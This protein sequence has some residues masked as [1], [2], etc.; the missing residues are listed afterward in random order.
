[1]AE[2]SAIFDAANLLAVLN[3]P[4][5]VYK[6]E[7]RHKVAKAKLKAKFDVQAGNSAE[8]EASTENLPEN[9]ELNQSFLIET[10]SKALEEVED[11]ELKCGLHVLVS[12]AYT[13][14]GKVSRPRSQNG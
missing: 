4:A 12:R 8:S 1:M 5:S 11:A 2:V 10:A 6:E 13:L 7:S 3:S 14:L 9:K